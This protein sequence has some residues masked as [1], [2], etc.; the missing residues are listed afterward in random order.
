MTAP[1][2]IPTTR[3]SDLVTFAILVDGEALSATIQVKSISVHREVNKVPFARI[4]IVDGD[5]AREDFPVSN[6]AYFTPGKEI[7]IRLGYRSDN[8]PVFKGIITHHA[9]KIS[10]RSAELQVECK[11]KA[12]KLTLGRKSKHYENVTDSDIAEEIIDKYGL[13]KEVEA[14]P[15]QHKDVIQFNTSDWDFML[16]RLDVMGR[17]CTVEDGKIILKKPDLGAASVLDVLY[18]ATI[19]D[20]QAEIDS[21]TQLNEVLSRTW[22]YSSQEVAEDTADIPDVPET[23][24]LSPTELAAVLGLESYQLIHA[25]RLTSGKL[26]E[27]ANA[28][29]LR[30]RLA[31]VKGTV[32]CKG[33]PDVKPG[34]II[35]L[36]GVG[37]RFNGPV[38]VAAVRQQ[39][40]S[41]S[42]TTE[43]EF[44]LPDTWFAESINPY[45]LSAQSGFM[46]SVQG[47]QIGVVTD[48]EDPEGE[49]RV[50]VRL[51]VVSMAEEGIWMRIATL[52]AGNNRGTFFRPEKDDEVIVGFIQNDPDN[53][54][55]LGMLHSSALPPP[56]TPSNDNHEKGYISRSEIKMIFNDDEKSY[57]LE[58]PGGKKITLNDEA[59]LVQVEDENGN[60]V[61]MEASGVTLESAGSLT[62]KAATDIT[63]AAVNISLSPSSQFSVSAAG[64]E[65]KAGAGSAEF[66]SAT[67][68]VE[69]SGLAE[70]KG[71]LVKIN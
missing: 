24:N 8:V 11:D 55:I 51:P 30:S 9:N 25:G 19:L 67:V 34:S 1:R 49:H 70:I 23:G 71:G 54:V 63:L 4:R 33:F 64:S 68:K 5:P 35:S 15:V 29:M 59:G 36:N 38:F 46:P 22:D 39:Y 10:F 60:M 28:R 13:E 58:T 37:E 42:W 44:G 26:K 50:K 21:R 57:V 12:V 20:Y 7:E 56:L 32:K 62:I 27:W 48:L 65:I 2:T 66:K 17:I 52:D 43:I 3:P 53:P 41:G 18:G 16:S 40:S 47:L 69:G 45:H 6:E 61:K 14:T 31:K